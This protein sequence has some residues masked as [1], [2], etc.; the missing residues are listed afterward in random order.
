M[1]KYRPYVAAIIFRKTKSGPRFLLLH[2]KQNWKGWEYVKGGLLP[3]ETE[4]S[5][6]KREVREETGIKKIRIITEL[7]AKVKYSWPKTFVKD[8]KKWQGALQHVYVVEIL[9]KKIKLDR[10]E[11]S[12]YKWVPAK[13]AVK[14]LTHKEPKSALSYALKNIFRL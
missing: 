8:R 3:A 14:L 10:A 12:G 9:S 6:L 2:R 5:G 11:H 7:P 13:T 1:V 4:I